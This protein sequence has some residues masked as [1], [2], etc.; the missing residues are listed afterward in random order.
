MY[1]CCSLGADLLTTVQRVLWRQLYF[2]R[3]IASDLKEYVH[4]ACCKEYPI[5]C[6]KIFKI[7][8]FV[9]N[10]VFFANVTSPFPLRSKAGLLKK[11]NSLLYCNKSDP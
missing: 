3:E 10:W 9:S 8:V 5:I 7:N 11:C 6:K 2:R 1:Y 4:I